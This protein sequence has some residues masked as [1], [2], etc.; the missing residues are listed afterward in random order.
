M[1]E[2]PSTEI[3]IRVL[4]LRDLEPVQRVHIGIQGT[5]ADPIIQGNSE[6]R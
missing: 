6:T 2:S 5:G 1:R 3:P 4:V